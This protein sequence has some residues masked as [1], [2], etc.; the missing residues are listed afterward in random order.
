MDAA[1]LWRFT[2]LGGPE[3]PSPGTIDLRQLGRYPAGPLLG[4]TVGFV[5]GLAALRRFPSIP[6]RLALGGSVLFVAAWAQEHVVWPALWPGGRYATFAFMMRQYSG[7]LPA[8]LAGAYV[9]L[10][11]WAA[12]MRQAELARRKP[13]RGADGPSSGLMSTLNLP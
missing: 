9:V 8:L 13:S 7:R 5:L 4:L 6:S 11:T 10:W 2:Y 12:G 1:G 3:P